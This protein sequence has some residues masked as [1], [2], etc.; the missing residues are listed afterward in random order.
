MILYG[1]TIS[2]FVRKTL[3]FATEKGLTLE[4]VPAGMGRGGPD[5]VEASPFGKMPGFRDPGADEGGG[6][7]T[8]SDSSAIV[9]YLEAKHPEPNL[10][11][12]DPANRARAIWY[13]EFADTIVMKMGGAIFF[14]RLVAPKF[15]NQPGNEDAAAAA[16]RDDLPPILDYL[17]RTIPAE[18]CLVAGR[19][20][21]A[22]LA[23]ASPFVNLSHVGI[24]IDATRYPRTAGYIA[25]I[26]ARPSFAPVIAAEQ[27]FLAKLG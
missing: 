12:A 13:E 9:Q 18:G 19:L 8:I 24:A 4:V 2:P 27:A 23:V 14:N 6:D 7:F 21:L 16:E 5:F 25:A 17:E 26:L 15:M 11:P 3:A 1:S 10:I 20:T 22:D